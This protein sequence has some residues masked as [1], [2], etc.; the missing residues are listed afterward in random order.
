[1]SKFN[2]WVDDSNLS[3]NTMDVTSDSQRSTGFQSGAAAS[4][5]R[6]NTMLRQN[7]LVVKSLMDIFDVEDTLSYSSTSDAVKAIMQQYFS[8]KV[9][10]TTFN[11]RTVAGKPLSSNVNLGTLTLKLLT[12]QQGATYDGSK[13]VT[14]DLQNVVDRNST[15]TIS[16]VKSFLNGLKVHKELAV[17]DDRT[18]SECRLSYSNDDSEGNSII[19][20]PKDGTVMLNT[21]LPKRYLHQICINLKTS[22]QANVKGYM[23]INLISSRTK[24][25]I[26]DFSTLYS[27]LLAEL[28]LNYQYLCSGRIYIESGVANEI[29]FFSL[30]SA[31]TIM[32]GTYDV[33]TGSYVEPMSYTY[34]A[35]TTSTYIRFYQVK[36]I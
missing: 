21:T 1:M 11:S 7:S 29:A 5:K 9:D 28:G 13:D 6:V 34:S 24:Q 33:D 26:T 27:F 19:F 18:G 30:T 15:Q 23:T 36:E 14:I 10:L 25:T 22:D 3:A 35:S 31:N 17:I 20:P 16:G 2:V 4:S 8:T 32:L 12:V